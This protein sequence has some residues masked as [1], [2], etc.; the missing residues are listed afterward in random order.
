MWMNIAAMIIQLIGVVEKVYQDIKGKGTVKKETVMAAT[1]VIVNDV[2]SVSTGGQKDTWE[3]M[4]PLVSSFVD[5]AVTISNDL[6]PGIV[7]DEDF[8]RSKAGLPPE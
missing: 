8:E 7:T 6:S 1:Q 2:A 5:M 4:A 3:S